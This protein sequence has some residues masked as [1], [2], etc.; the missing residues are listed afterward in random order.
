MSTT[1]KSYPRDDGFRMPGEFEPHQGCW[2]LWPERGDTWRLGAKPA[3]EAFAAVA[4]AISRFEPVTVGVSG[5]QL[6]N[7][8]R[9]LPDH[10]RIAEI[11]SDDAWMRDVGPTFVVNGRTREIRGI[12]WQFNA[13]GGLEKGLYYPWDQDDR[14]ACIVL[15]LERIDRY[16]APFIL[17]GGAIHVDGQ[18]T[19][20]TTESCLLNVNRNQA[21]SK[22]KL[23]NYLKS[24]LGVDRIIWIPE[25]VYLDET[26]GHVDNL[27]CFVKPGVVAL[28][29]TDDPQDPQ[30]KISEK[31]FDILTRAKD[32]RG[33]NLK[34]HKIH[35]PGPLFMTVAE[36]SGLDCSEN[37][38]HRKAGDRL[39]GSYINFYMANG[40]IVMPLFGDAH[41]IAAQQALQTLFP[42]RDVV[43]V[44][45]RE[46]LL[47][48]GNIHCITQQVP[49]VLSIRP[50]KGNGTFL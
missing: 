2:M 36:S 12:D 13:W 46:I 24:F 19:L 35:Q 22:R 1:L 28:N 47:G 37:A 41:D 23:E 34:V 6:T 18:G 50:R 17:E 21:L 38:R 26:D 29:W 3:Q 15:E 5:R 48:G 8:R 43:G 33:K 14:V 16:R 4:A 30:R 10:V 20:I 40:G 44:Q 27:C 9:L 11:A 49:A 39:A 7:A 42:D 25:G 32:A 45:A 31:A